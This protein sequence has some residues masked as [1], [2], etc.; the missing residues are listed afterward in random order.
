ML[1]EQEL[2]RVTCVGQR[3]LW[4]SMSGA[5]P[6]TSMVPSQRLWM[7]SYLI[8]RARYF[9]RFDEPRLDLRICNGTVGDLAGGVGQLVVQN[10][11]DTTELSR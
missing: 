2:G 10:A 1:S 11:L 7:E 3:Q 6:P 5:S 4:L 8:W 9:G